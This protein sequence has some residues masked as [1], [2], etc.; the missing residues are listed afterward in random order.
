MPTDSQNHVRDCFLTSKRLGLFWDEWSSATSSDWSL[1]TI[2]K[3]FSHVIE[4]DI[5]TMSW[6]R[7]DCDLDYQPMLSICNAIQVKSE[8]MMMI[9]E[10]RCSINSLLHSVRNRVWI[11]P[12]NC[13]QRYTQVIVITFKVMS[14]I[15]Q[16]GQNYHWL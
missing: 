4:S 7:I 15:C 2:Q 10:Q 14:F 9:S 12:P 8:S 16:S 3:R 6:H 5:E 1:V 13:K 11:L